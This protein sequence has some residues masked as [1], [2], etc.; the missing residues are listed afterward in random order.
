MKEKYEG[1]VQRVGIY[2]MNSLACQVNDTQKEI[3]GN[4]GIIEVSETKFRWPPFVKLFVDCIVNFSVR[5]KEMLTLIQLRITDFNC[6]EVLEVAWS[7][8]WNVTDETP[9]NCRRFLENGG[10]DCFIKCLEVRRITSLSGAC[11]LCLIL[12]F[13]VAAISRKTRTNAQHDGSAWERGRS[14]GITARS[15]AARGAILQFARLDAR[16]DRGK[17]L[18]QIILKFYEQ[19]I[20]R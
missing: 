13:S 15:D 17:I 9:I 11:R 8:M 10:M 2:L 3:L 19:R 12:I 18:R 6:D 20:K 5:L 16:R 4:M 7:T 14:Y 1:F